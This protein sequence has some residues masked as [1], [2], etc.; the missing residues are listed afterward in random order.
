MNQLLLKFLQQRESPY[1]HITKVMSAEI[2]ISLKSAYYKCVIK[3][4][5]GESF[6]SA[7]ETEN[8]AFVNI[9]VFNEWRQG[10]PTILW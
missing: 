9:N 10:N 2:D 8:I 5:E 3:T 1:L 7:D 6:T 4:L